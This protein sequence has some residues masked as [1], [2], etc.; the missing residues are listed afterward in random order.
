M[1]IQA[2]TNSFFG[3]LICCIAFLLLTLAEFDSARVILD[4]LVCV[5][6]N[7]RFDWF[8]LLVMLIGKLVHLLVGLV[9]LL[10]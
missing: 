5:L 10:N 1:P 8:V 7:L 3:F 9:P 2:S 6:G 4:L